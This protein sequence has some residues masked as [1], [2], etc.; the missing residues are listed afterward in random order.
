MPLVPDT[1]GSPKLSLNPDYTHNARIIE[2]PKKP[3]VFGI[4]KCLSLKFRN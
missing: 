3:T 1:R 2:L 4:R